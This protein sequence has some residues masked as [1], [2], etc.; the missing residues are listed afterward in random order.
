MY[1]IVLFGHILIVHVL[2][3]DFHQKPKVSRDCVQLQITSL[4]AYC[5]AVL[6]GTISFVL[7]I[8][9]WP[10]IFTWR[11]WLKRRPKTLTFV[12][13]GKRNDPWLK[14]KLDMRLSKTWLP[15]NINPIES[16]G[17]SVCNPCV[18]EESSH[19]DLI[20]CDEI[21]CKPMGELIML[22]MCVSCIHIHL[23]IMMYTFIL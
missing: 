1:C 5:H 14:G 23:L 20:P 19:R 8:G 3:I 9:H 16:W 7:I 6:F 12:K 21:L 13:S 17:Y 18:E 2:C 22:W 4:L 10:I 11:N 15:V